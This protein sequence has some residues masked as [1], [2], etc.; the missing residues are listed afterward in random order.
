MGLVQRA[1]CSREMMAK[2]KWL[3]QVLQTEMK[4]GSK[5][6]GNTSLRMCTLICH[7][8]AYLVGRRIWSENGQCLS[9]VWPGQT[10]ANWDVSVFTRT[11][12]ECMVC[13]PCV[14]VM[15]FTL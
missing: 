12:P 10:P 1:K 14:S 8:Q 15:C 6:E 7:S 3:R 13:V 2:V 4:A 9:C 11:Q 5:E